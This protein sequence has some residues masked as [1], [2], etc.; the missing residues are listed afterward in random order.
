MNL[1]LTSSRRTATA[2]WS[3]LAVLVFSQL[4]AAQ[5]GDGRSP[6]A[7]Q[8]EARTKT[9]RWKVG[10]TLQAVGGPCAGLFATVPVPTEWPEQKVKIVDEDI[11][12]EVSRVKYRIL[13]NGV[14]QMLITVPRL[15]GGK[16]AQA[17]VTFEVERE[18]IDEPADPESLVIP[19]KPPRAVTKYLGAS[20]FI[21]VRHREIRDLAKE[22]K[23]ESLSD[24]EQI[25][26]F[27]DTVRERVEYRNGKLK[28]ALAALRDGNGDCEEL[29][30]LFIALCRCHGVPAR[31]VWI[32]GHCYPEFYLED[33]D[34]N[35]YWLPC[36][37]AGTRA[38]GSM[39]E[40]RPI[41]QKGD[42]FKV[43]EKK[44]RQRYV[45]EYLTGKAIRG[46]GKPRVSFIRDELAPE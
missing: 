33:A 2:G 31:T 3:L 46:G 27:Y 45:A 26:K 7:T 34:E 40:L 8:A 38:F 10:V 19:K 1:P 18:W 16:S 39:P 20:P 32:P 22:L 30:S 35:G 25:E 13:D 44:K 42:N 23:D 9:A 37:A 11:S 17:H 12:P 5:F 28:G 21:E 43:P 15:A 29:T 24:W 4:A 36:Q 41:L 6:A 14:K